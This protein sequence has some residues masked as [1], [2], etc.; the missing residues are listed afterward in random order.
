MKFGQTRQ[1][2]EFT[3][4]SEP[5]R[6]HLAFCL[7][8]YFLVGIIEYSS[9]TF[10]RILQMSGV[11]LFVGW[12]IQLLYVGFLLLCIWWIGWWRYCFVCVWGGGGGGG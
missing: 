8:L 4:Q 3:N 1:D 10:V 6:Q 2:N 12:F 5:E 7:G 9:V 11:D